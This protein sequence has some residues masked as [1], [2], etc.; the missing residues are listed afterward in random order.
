MRGCALCTVWHGVATDY[1]AGPDEY[2]EMLGR[3]QPGD[4]LLLKSGDYRQGLPLHE[5]SGH[6]DQPIIIEALYP[7]APLL[8]FIARPGPIRS[9]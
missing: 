9:V 4:R 2:R 7:S 6:S 3:L 8:R 1:R 5:L